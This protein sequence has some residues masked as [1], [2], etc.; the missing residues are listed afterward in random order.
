ML[1]A[2]GVEEDNILKKDS[3]QQFYDNAIS[4]DK[5][6]GLNDI[7]I[8]DIAYIGNEGKFGHPIFV[9]RKD[10]DQIIFY[11]NSMDIREGGLIYNLIGAV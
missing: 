2:G 5:F 6:P 7:N 10:E 4:W 3:R 8:G 1:L 11:G 9:I